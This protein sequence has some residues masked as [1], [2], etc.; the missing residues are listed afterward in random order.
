[1]LFPVLVWMRNAQCSIPFF[2][3]AHHGLSV[4]DGIASS[5]FV[6]GSFCF[7]YCRLYLPDLSSFTRISLDSFPQGGP[8]PTA[9]LTQLLALVE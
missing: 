5:L 2:P 1:M 3:P 6:Q 8:L 4:P 7:Y 9:G